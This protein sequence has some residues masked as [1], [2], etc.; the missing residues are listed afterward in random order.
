MDFHKTELLHGPYLPPA[1]QRGDR[2]T[3]L[4]RDAEVTITSWTD[5][6]IPWPRCRAIGRRG[7]PGL[8]VTEELIRAIRTES[9]VAIQHWFGVTATT[10]WRWRKAFGVTRWGSEGS[11]RLH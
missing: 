6:P 4:F 7:R 1:L 8:L 10:V 2:T 5:A 11:R 3:Y 9:S